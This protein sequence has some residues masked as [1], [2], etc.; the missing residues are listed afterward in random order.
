MVQPYIGT[1]CSHK[2]EW[3]ADT[4]TVL[5]SFEN[6]LSEINQTQKTDSCVIPFIRYLEW[7]KILETENSLGDGGKKKRFV[8]V[9]LGDRKVLKTVVMAAQRC[10]M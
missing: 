5:V 10:E 2:K 4:C 1:L 3:S 9:L 7:E 8:T 6:M